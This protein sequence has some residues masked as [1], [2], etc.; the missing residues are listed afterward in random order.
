M[1]IGKDYSPSVPIFKASSGRILLARISTAIACLLYSFVIEDEEI[2]LE[3]NET[4]VACAEKFLRQLYN[5]P[6]FG[7]DTYSSAVNYSNIDEDEKDLL[8]KRC[9]EAL[10]NKKDH[11][12]LFTQSQV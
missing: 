8:W 10:G 1:A 6:S 4:H 9:K 7:Y 12:E 3:V 5:K 11:V 2:Y